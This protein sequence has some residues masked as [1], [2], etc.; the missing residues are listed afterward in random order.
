MNSGDREAIRP[1]LDTNAPKFLGGLGFLVEVQHESG[2]FDLRKTESATATHIA[3][4]LRERRSGAFL[5]AS[6]DVE[7]AEPHHVAGLILD[8][9]DPPDD[10]L[11]PDELAGARVDAARR[12]LL[13]DGIARDLQA[14]YIDLDLARQMIAAVR[15]H[16]AHGDYDSIDRG[17]AFARKMTDDLR[18]ISR[19][20]HLHVDYGP[21]AGRSEHETPEERLAWLRAIHFGF[22]QIERM[23]GNIAHVKLDEV[24]ESDTAE[25][26]QFIADSMSGI[27]D[28]DALLLD[29]RDNAGGSPDTVQR[30][31]SYLFGPTPVHLNDLFKRDNHSTRAFWTLRDLP[32]RRFGPKK[33]VYVLVSKNTV[34]GGEELAYDL[35]S[36][37]RAKVVGETTAGG[38]HAV[39]NFDLDAQFRITVPDQTA[40]NPVTKKGWEGV[41]V[42]PDIG[43]PA[44]SALNEAHHRALADLAASKAA[45]AGHR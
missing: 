43:V 19:D 8:P 6:M 31:A 33:P 26:Q 35:Q 25:A 39:A 28:A 30:I 32:G 29:L 23:D 20:I 1:Y 36:L 38:G 11:S 7:D 42:V 10:V 41:G 37:H 34:S 21:V 27:A 3:V 17:W 22:A 18:A 44:D 5:R 16:A 13:I 40:I 45:P 15:D 14:H 2:G 12:A 24:P 4:I 9:V